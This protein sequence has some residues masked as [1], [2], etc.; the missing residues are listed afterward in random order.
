[1]SRGQP[2]AM[3]RLAENPK[4]ETRMAHQIRNQN[5]EWAVGSGFG[6]LVLCILALVGVS[7]AAAQ[8]VSPVP[9]YYASATPMDA[10]TTTLIVGANQD[11]GQS[12]VSQDRRYVTLDPSLLG[13]ARIRGF[14]YQKG[15][16]GFVGS[17][18]SL[19]ILSPV[20]NGLTPTIKSS[21]SE[22]G[23]SDSVLDRAGMVFIAPLER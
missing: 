22:I 11:V 6:F 14:T 5:D 13:S 18:A 12:I 8:D 3:E 20:G 19:G 2:N 4:P 23:P 16:K 1:M 17:E 9:F 7:R 21:P 10:Q 15:G